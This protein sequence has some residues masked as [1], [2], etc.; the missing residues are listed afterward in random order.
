MRWGGQ[1]GLAPTLPEM[2][3][4][5]R[6]ECGEKLLLKGVMDSKAVAKTVRIE[7]NIETE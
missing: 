5:G 2:G 7:P 1:K 6:Y 4:Q 3:V